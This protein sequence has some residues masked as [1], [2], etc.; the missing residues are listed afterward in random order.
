MP[1]LTSL[2][3]HAFLLDP[4]MD[5]S[6]AISGNKHAEL[7]KLDALLRIPG[8]NLSAKAQEDLREELERRTRD[9]RGHTLLQ[10]PPPAFAASLRQG[11][12]RAALEGRR[13]AMGALPIS[14][15]VAGIESFF[16]VYAIESIS[17]THDNVTELPTGSAYVDFKSHVDAQHALQSLCSKKFQGN[18][19][20]LALSRDIQNRV[21]DDGIVRS[22]TNTSH[23]TF[24]TGPLT[25]VPELRNLRF[26]EPNTQRDNDLSDDESSRLST[27]VTTR[28]KLTPKLQFVER[29]LPKNRPF[30]EKPVN[31]RP[32]S[33]T[34]KPSGHAHREWPAMSKARNLVNGNIPPLNGSRGSQRKS[35]PVVIAE[36]GQSPPN[37]LEDSLAQM[38]LVD[39]DR[40]HYTTPTELGQTMVTT[41]LGQSVQQG[42]CK[43]LREFLDMQNDYRA[44]ANFKPLELR[45]SGDGCLESS[46][47]T[48]LQ[49]SSQ[50]QVTEQHI[51][52]AKRWSARE[53]KRERNLRNRK[54]KAKKREKKAK[55]AA[56]RKQ[57]R[58]AR[59]PMREADV[60]VI[61]DDTD[62]DELAME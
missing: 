16:N 32:L 42:D 25:L 19:I 51:Q 49:I 2:N 18:E 39:D 27:P 31:G 30:I 3:R 29:P 50:C 6:C 15:T 37:A 62:V 33:R 11:L 40:A 26:A 43:L 53:A 9:M 55:R 21:K 14:V 20:T 24:E 8:Q 4:A 5:V 7:V 35:M 22:A 46:I 28:V 54:R 34:R 36:T 58:N 44:K 13:I 47:I 48:D 1:L 61:S 52:A 38:S 57:K 23:E 56:K 41:N 10:P 45:L 12:E 17:M 60:I 59:R